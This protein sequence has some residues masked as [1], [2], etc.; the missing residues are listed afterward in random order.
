[1]PRTHTHFL[2]LSLYY[3]FAVSFLEQVL[4]NNTQY[5]WPDA[6]F[7]FLVYMYI[8]ML[9]LSSKILETYS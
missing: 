6:D 2:S 1:M 9:I 4:Q 7:F 5:T 8:Y 3:I